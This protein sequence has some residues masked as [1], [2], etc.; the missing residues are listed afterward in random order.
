MKSNNFLLDAGSY[1][2]RTINA[3]SAWVG[4]LPF[5][6]WLVQTQRPRTL[7]ELGT[8]TGNSYFTFCQAVKDAG[9]KT[10]CYAVD[11]WQG[12]EHAGEYGE[13]IYQ[14][15]KAINTD[16]Y[17]AFSTLLRMTFDQA[18]EVI[19]DGTVDLLH[20]DGLHTYEAVRHDFET[21]LP[22]L[23]P[24]AMVLFH[25]THV[26][27]RGFGVWQYWAE[28]RA[29]YPHGF[30]FEHSHGLGVLQ[31]GEGPACPAIQ[32]MQSE[33]FDRLQTYFAALGNA[34]LDRFHHLEADVRLHAEQNNAQAQI[35]YRDALVTELKN[36]LQA[37][38]DNALAQ[39]QYR[40]A[41]VADLRAQ[42]QGEKANAEAQILYR[43]SLLQAEKEQANL[44]VALK[45]RLL[46]EAY[47]LRGVIRHIRR[48]LGNG[49]KS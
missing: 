7:V 46:Q 34:Q 2:P 35:L 48:K 36:F 33:G 24:N 32:A 43:D 42:L 37:E 12:D 19:P 40:D 47:T 11:T 25:D 16:H 18:L 15:V 13:D 27:E 10:D 31:V 5:A 26:Y 38:K 1:Q 17:A 9:C 49:A 22:K 4:H 8:H 44:Q 41:L 3:P 30:A 28:V 21:W 6:W 39:I 23:S 45:E 20:I 14:Q 29:Q